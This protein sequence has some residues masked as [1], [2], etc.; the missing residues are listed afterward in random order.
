MLSLTRAS[1][2]AT[3]VQPVRSSTGTVTSNSSSIKAIIERTT[4]E[5]Q[6][7]ATLKSDCRSFASTPNISASFARKPLLISV[8]MSETLQ[9]ARDSDHGRRPRIPDPEPNQ[10]DPLSTGDLSSLPRPLQGQWNRRGDGVAAI[11]HIDTELVGGDLQLVAQ[12][13]EHEPI[14]LMEH[15]VIHR[16]PAVGLAQKLFHYGRD[17]TQRKVED[18]RSVHVQILLRPPIAPF[19]LGGHP[20]FRVRAVPQPPNGY[21]E[22][23]RS[24]AIGPQDERTD[25]FVLRIASDHQGRRG[26]VSEDRA[27]RA[28]PRMQKLAIGIRGD[29]QYARCGTGF[30]EALRQHQPVDKSGAPLVDVQGAAAGAQAEPGLHRARRG[31]QEIVGALRTEY[32]KVDIPRVAHPVLEQPL[33]S[34][35]PK[36]RGALV[37]RRDPP[38]AD[39]G[40]L[41]DLVGGPVAQFVGEV[42]VRQ[43]ARRQMSPDGRDSRVGA[44]SVAHD[45]VPCC[46]PVKTRERL[47]CIDRT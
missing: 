46:Q 39:A 3:D 6:R 22:L 20:R 4:T 34:R 10:H 15:E 31:R 26:T 42:F 21:D 44:L 43:L 36:I 5:S 1:T 8:S 30:D 11:L 2:S 14:R 27:H 37:R 47:V 7:S 9:L 19:G 45:L 28:I 25:R 23:T 32:Q 18:L 24:P 41:K 16:R 12:P 35:D 29:Q 38:R 40:L 33:R 17:R 13:L